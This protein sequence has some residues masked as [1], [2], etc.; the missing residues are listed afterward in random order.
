MPRSYTPWIPSS[1][2][3][4]SMRYVNEY[5]GKN[6]ELLQTLRVQEENK[7]KEIEKMLSFQNEIKEKNAKI[8]LKKR[9]CS[10]GLRIYCADREKE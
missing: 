2:V 10:A 3:M 9:N 7:K 4:A 5:M 8:N 6:D 1:F